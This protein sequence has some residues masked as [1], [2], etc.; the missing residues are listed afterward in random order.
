MKRKKCTDQELQRT[1]QLYAGLII[2]I[3][4]III[5]DILIKQ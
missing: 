4:L 5:I 3:V 1:M 2:G